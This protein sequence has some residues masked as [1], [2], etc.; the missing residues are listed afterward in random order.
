M[1]CTT[2]QTFP[3]TFKQR[4]IH[5]FTQDNSAFYLVAHGYFQTWTRLWTFE[6]IHTKQGTS[7]HWLWAN[8]S[9]HGHTLGGLCVCVVKFRTILCEFST[10]MRL[11]FSLFFPLHSPLYHAEHFPSSSIQQSTWSTN[12]LCGSL[13]QSGWLTGVKIIP[14]L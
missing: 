11:W 9:E 10:H 13:L 2:S 1:F 3:N 5:K 4:E 7:L 14:L 8:V 12:Q 6:F